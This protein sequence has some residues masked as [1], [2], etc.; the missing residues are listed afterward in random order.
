MKDDL[1]IS[2]MSPFILTKV[3]R[4]LSLHWSTKM[5]LLWLGN[6]LHSRVAMNTSLGLMASGT[7]LTFKVPASSQAHLFV[8]ILTPDNSIHLYNSRKLLFKTFFMNFPN[9][10]SYIMYTLFFSCNL[11]KKLRCI[12]YIE[13][14][15]FICPS[16]NSNILSHL[17]L[18]K[19]V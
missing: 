13:Q 7:L 14:L 11:F 8:M 16:V 2:A 18:N 15:M 9:S 12:L 17:S 19:T 4:H 5:W 3:T 10:Y 1:P 6:S